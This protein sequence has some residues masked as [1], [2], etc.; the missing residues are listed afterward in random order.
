MFWLITGAFY[1]GNHMRIL[2]PA[3]TATTIEGLVGVA[4][5]GTF[6]ADLQLHGLILATAIS[7][8]LIG[9]PHFARTQR[10][11]LLYAAWANF[12]SAALWLFSALD[13]V[14]G[15]GLVLAR[16]EFGQ[17]DVSALT[18]LPAAT[19]G[20]VYGLICG[21][22]IMARVRDRQAAWV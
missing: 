4:A 20:I 13:V 2:V 19:S 9:S 6:S 16:N 5:I 12:A 14:K 21:L 22:T 11:A 18:F 7:L 17:L 10:R 8:G 1:R 3:M 15:A